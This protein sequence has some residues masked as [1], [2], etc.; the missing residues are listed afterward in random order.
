MKFASQ[1]AA[2]GKKSREVSFVCARAR[3]CVCVCVCSLFLG[4]TTPV[5]VSKSDGSVFSGMQEE[6]RSALQNLEVCLAQKPLAAHVMKEIQV[7]KTT[8]VSTNASLG[9]EKRQTFTTSLCNSSVKVMVEHGSQLL[10]EPFCANECFAA[11]QVGNV[12]VHG[13]RGVGKSTMSQALCHAVGCWPNLA[14]TSIVECK[15]LRG[16]FPFTTRRKV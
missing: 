1:P 12:L 6:F 14:H 13:P 8:A 11:L 10:T 2:F 9:C 7:G 5:H 16:M 3:V 15:P 4:D